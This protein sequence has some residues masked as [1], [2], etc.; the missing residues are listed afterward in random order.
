M[1][2]LK[3][4]AISGVVLTMSWPSA[5]VLRS[6]PT[7]YTVDDLGTL[8]GAPL[9]PLSINAS[10]HVVGTA[11]SSDGGTV[12]FFLDSGPARDI[13]SLGGTRIMASA[14]NDRDQVVGFS[15][16]ATGALRAFR[17]APSTGLSALAMPEGFASLAYAINSPG[18]IAGFGGT[19]AYHAFRYEEGAGVTDLGT[20]GGF[21]S[22]GYGINE[23]GQVT[24]C[25]QFSNYSLHA[26]V[27]DDAQGMHDLG[28]L[29]GSQ[30][31]GVGINR[32]G[33]IAGWS[34]LAGDMFTHAFRYSPASGLQDLGSLGGG[35]SVATGINDN[36]A[37]IGWSSD[38]TGAH[39]AFMFT[40]A[41]GLVDLN[42]LIDPAL[43]WVLLSANGINASGQI[44]GVGLL[45]GEQRA[46][47]VTPPPVQP[48]PD[49]TEPPAIRWIQPSPPFLWPPHG[50]MVPVRVHV[51]A[52]DDMDAR[53]TCRIARVTSSE[54]DSGTSRLD[55]SNDIIVTGNLTVRLRSELAFKSR[56]RIY[57]LDVTCADSAGNQAAAQATVR[58][59]SMPWGWFRW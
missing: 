51:A 55:R 47:R 26:F 25:S 36:G 43:G 6:D 9:I 5:Q 39:R 40:D 31:W 13:G 53:P 45:G 44:V 23:S 54:P 49:D 33:Q 59:L 4:A 22:Y 11:D 29:G 50:G 42:T 10:G 18:Q 24:G 37:V 19:D 7:P 20:L 56:P 32:S 30:S 58:V 17:Y 21:S 34:F 41:D 12:G 57:T 15:T 1:Q 38:S 2:R 28:T 14:V 27:W 52:R 8:N 3:L 16:D 48:A 35:E 46:F